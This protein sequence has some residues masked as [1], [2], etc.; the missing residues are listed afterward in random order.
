MRAWRRARKRRPR[1]SR[2]GA[3]WPVHAS[4]FEFELPGY[5][6]PVRVFYTRTVIYESRIDELVFKIR[7]LARALLEPLARR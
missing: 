5:A 3:G 4:D 2:A 7:D 1:G 6:T